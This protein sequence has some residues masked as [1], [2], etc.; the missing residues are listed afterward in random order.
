MAW[1]NEMDESDLLTIGN[2]EIEELDNDEIDAHEAAF[3][4][5]YN[6]EEEHKSQDVEEEY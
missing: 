1:D 4:Q 2:A 6:A 3:L 5:G